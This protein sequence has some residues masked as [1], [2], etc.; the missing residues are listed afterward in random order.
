MLKNATTTTTTVILRM[1]LDALLHG[2]IH[3]S[4]AIFQRLGVLSFLC[5]KHVT[6]QGLLEA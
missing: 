4:V 6:K 3:L 5:L 2:L 1:T